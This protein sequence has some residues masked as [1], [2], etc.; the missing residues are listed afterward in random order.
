MKTCYDAT[1]QNIV[2][3]VRFACHSLLIAMILLNLMTQN[4]AI[5]LLCALTGLLPKENM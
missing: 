2:D 3:F 4:S 5:G 1:L